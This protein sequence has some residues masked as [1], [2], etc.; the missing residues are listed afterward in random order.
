MCPGLLGL[1]AFLQLLKV[2]ALRRWPTLEATHRFEPIAI[3]AAHAWLYRGQIVP[4]NRRVEVEA[5]ITGVDDGPRPMIAANG[6]LKVDGT[7]IYE[8][9]DFAM[10]LVPA[11]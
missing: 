5:A 1:E 7:V 4:T 11:E 6:F 3:G 2:V 9:T 10:R 8:M